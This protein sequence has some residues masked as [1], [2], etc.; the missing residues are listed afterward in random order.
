[1]LR[2]TVTFIDEQLIRFAQNRTAPYDLLKLSDKVGH[3]G[4]LRRKWQRVKR[5]TDKW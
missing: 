5:G 1:M 3:A 2:E 4:R